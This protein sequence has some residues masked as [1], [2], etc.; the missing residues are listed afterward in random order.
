MDPWDASKALQRSCRSALQPLGLDEGR[1]SGLAK[2]A[3][4]ICHKA[5]QSMQVGGG[6]RGANPRRNSPGTFSGHLF[7]WSLPYRASS[8]FILRL[9]SRGRVC[10][11]PGRDDP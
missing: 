11:E 7:F 4:A 6:G 9:R 10:D 5:S 8:P 2:T 1:V 3:E